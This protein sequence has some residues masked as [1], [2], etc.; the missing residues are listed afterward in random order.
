MMGELIRTRYATGKSLAGDLMSGS[1]P[2]ASGDAMGA[3]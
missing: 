1:D 2:V 3:L